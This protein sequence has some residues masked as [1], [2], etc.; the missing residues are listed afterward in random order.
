MARV[1]S[2]F[3][4]LYIECLEKCVT[5][6][7]EVQSSEK[8]KIS[9]LHQLGQQ[10]DLMVS[11]APEGEPVLKRLARDITKAR[12]KI[13]DDR[14]LEKCRQLYL[15]S[16]DL[17]IQDFYECSSRDLTVSMIFDIINKKVSNKKEKDSNTVFKVL[18]KKIWRN[19]FQVETLIQNQPLTKLEKE[20][21]SE[22]ILRIKE[23]SRSILEL[24]LHGPEK[25]KLFIN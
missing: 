9:L 7:E 12:K 16:N 23:M 4:K 10:I 17:Q 3:N 5:I 6:I 15:F 11:N 22:K 20:E 21:I 25:R 14:Q 13:V 19:L 18:I 8:H 24:F 2:E 1:I